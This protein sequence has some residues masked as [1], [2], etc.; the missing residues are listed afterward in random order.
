MNHS[1]SSSIKHDSKAKSVL[2]EL[3]KI[4]DP[5]I[6]QFISSIPVDLT[7]AAYRLNKNF[8][9]DDLIIKNRATLTRNIFNFHNEAQTLT[10]SVSVGL[11]LLRG[12][13]TD[14]L[15]A[16][17]QPNLFAYGGV[18]K[19]FILLKELQDAIYRLNPQRKVVTMFVIVDH[20]FIGD[21]WTK[22]AQLPNARSYDGIMEIR[23]P[24]KMKERWQMTHK[25]SPPTMS[26]LTF[27]KHQIRNWIK[28]TTKALGNDSSTYLGNL[29]SFWKI[30]EK[31]AFASK[32]YADFNSFLISNIVNI[33]WGH[34]TLFARLSEMQEVFV[35]G[36]SFLIKNFQQY[37]TCL[38]ETESVF[39]NSGITTG[40]SPNAYL[41]APIWL[42]CICGSKA[43]GSVKMDGENYICKGICISCKRD[44]TTNLGTLNNQQF[45]EKL[46]QIS[47]RAIPILLLLSMDL[48]CSGIVIGTGGS[49][50]YTI[51]ASRTF[52]RLNIRMPLPIIWAS[53]D[54]Y[55][56]IAQRE[57]LLLTKKDQ[58]QSI[59]Q[60]KVLHNEVSLDK[61]SIVPLIRERNDRFKR[62]VSIDSILQDIQKIKQRQRTTRESI[63]MITRS[64]NMLNM[65]P[66]IIDYAVN[67]GIEKIGPLWSKK[68]VNSNDLFI[69]ITYLDE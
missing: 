14:L 42:H 46:F 54:E 24:V 13:D 40:M 34:S 57:A 28:Y 16:I 12:D 25:N 69:P 56:G 66:C 44:I 64:L 20:D 39:Q 52:D 22:V 58:I 47:P 51:V 29:N 3:E 45:A 55:K 11:D 59:N 61:S 49:L 10:E 17:H 1:I 43:S 62:N 21:H 50:R 5:I 67:F 26:M 38:K 53:D 48:G 15:V 2:Q 41:F 7:T 18:F 35:R 33:S 4:H 37:S 27:W 68:L 60:L 6:D 65:K 31:S 19:K 63:R 9:A 8:Q 30:V 32:S 36:M 23:F